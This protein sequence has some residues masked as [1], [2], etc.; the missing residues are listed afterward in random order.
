MIS[1]ELLIEVLGGDVK[2][3]SIDKNNVYYDI[4]HGTSI[5]IYELAHKCKQW[6]FDKGYSLESAKRKVLLDENKMVDIW[7]CCGFTPYN[8]VLPD[9][10]EESEPEAIF[11]ACQWVLDN[12]DNQCYKDKHFI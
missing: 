7:I 4:D 8:E 1:K 11:K 3:F 10:T 6:A 5:N 12:K 9:F 2:S